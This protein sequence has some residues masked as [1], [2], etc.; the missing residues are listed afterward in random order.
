MA[1]KAWKATSFNYRFFPILT[2]PLLALFLHWQHYIARRLHEIERELHLHVFNFHIF[3][4]FTRTTFLWAHE[5]CPSHALSPLQYTMCRVLRL[6]GVSWRR[7]TYI[8]GR[9]WA[10]E[11]AFMILIYSW[12]WGT[13]MLLYDYAELADSSLTQFRA[14]GHVYF[15]KTSSS[16]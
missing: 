6:W 9:V 12:E 15:M 1:S 8:D 2:S 5:K 14:V 13:L 10:H 4:D 3:S 16:S 7:P 11:E